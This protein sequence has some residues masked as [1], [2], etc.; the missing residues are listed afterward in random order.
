[1]KIT[2]LYKKYTSYFWYGTFCLAILLWIGYEDLTKYD[3]MLEDSSEIKIYLKLDGSFSDSK[4]KELE[5]NKGKQFWVHQLNQVDRR[6][7]SYRNIDRDYTSNILDSRRL[8]NKITEDSYLKRLS[9]VKSDNEKKLIQNSHE[10]SQLKQ[11]ADDL[12]VDSNYKFAKEMAEVEI[13][14][15]EALRALILLKLEQYK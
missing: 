15:Y 1:M 6:L 11:K 14:K 3:K 2:L 10:V 9:E 8:R 13:P 4:F 5:K 12:E 7:A